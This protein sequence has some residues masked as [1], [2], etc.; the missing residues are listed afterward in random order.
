MYDRIFAGTLLLLSGLLAWAATQFKVPFQYEP[1][2]PKAFPII[3]AVILAISSIY[4]FAKPSTNSWK[5]SKSVILKLI[6]A[7]AVFWMYA[8]LYEPLG[9]IVAN[10]VVGALFSWFFG[11]RPIKALLYALILSVVSYF[12]LTSA[13]QLNVPL[14]KIFG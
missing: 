8:Y 3:I 7:L 9:F 4:L 2:G 12:L 10:T 1:L 14:G 5:P 11:E 13:L 6:G